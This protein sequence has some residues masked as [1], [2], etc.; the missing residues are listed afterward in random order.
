MGA[1]DHELLGWLRSARSLHILHCA[2][3]DCGETTAVIGMR[4]YGS[5]QIVKLFS[6]P[7]LPAAAAPQSPEPDVPAIAG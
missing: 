3:K 7:L 5:T 4:P 1:E 6:L 2:P